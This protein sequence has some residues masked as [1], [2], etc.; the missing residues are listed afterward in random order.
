MVVQKSEQK[1]RLELPYPPWQGGVITVI[2]F[3][4]VSP[5]EITVS[6]F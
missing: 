3:L 4:Q 6:R 2:L 5:P 1:G